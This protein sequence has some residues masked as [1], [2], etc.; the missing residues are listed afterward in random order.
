MPKAILLVIVEWVITVGDAV[1]SLPLAVSD[2]TSG[3]PAVRHNRWN[4]RT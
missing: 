1:H 4:D 3:Q 2:R